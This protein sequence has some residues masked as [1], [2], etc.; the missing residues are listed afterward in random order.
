MKA[1][2]VKNNSIGLTE[3]T[4]ILD[5]CGII[6]W[7]SPSI[8]DILGYSPDE[9]IGREIF[10]LV[11]RV[12]T[13]K[14]KHL[15]YKVHH[16]LNQIDEGMMQ[17]IKKNG[18]TIPVFLTLT[19]ITAQPEMNGVVIYLQQFNPAKN[20]T[21]IPVM[22]DQAEIEVEL[23]SKIQ[24]E[25]AAELHDHVSPTLAGVKMIIDY[26]IHSGNI[27]IDEVKNLPETL[28]NLISTVRDLSHNIMKKANGGFE[29]NEAL[30]SLLKGFMNYTQIRIVLKYEKP[31]EG[32]FRI[33]HKVH[34]VRI[35]QEQL[36]NIIKHAAATKVLICVQRRNGRIF[37]TTKDNGKGFD[38][39]KNRKGIGVSNMYYRVN[40]L[41]GNMHI[42][43]K[44][45]EGTTIT[46]ALPID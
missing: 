5:Y 18:E 38:P 13:K 8:N 35:I 2:Q 32:V 40:L 42:H 12:S 9:I 41:N 1:D 46:I 25:I 4:F 29:L 14:L 17:L 44:C 26:A 33:N 36:M 3:S 21:G 27:H 31:V 30:N 19:K 45:G 20:G 22:S 11:H 15:Y 6:Q 34:L 28:G 23:R 16:H 37:V 39:E 7:V 43:S 24:H 10:E